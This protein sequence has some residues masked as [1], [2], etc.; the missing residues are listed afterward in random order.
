MSV[1][2]MLFCPDGETTVSARYLV[3]CDG[4]SSTVR[5][6]LGAKLEDY[7]FDEPWLVVDL[8]GNDESDLPAVNTQICDPARPATF[9]RMGPGRHRWE[10]MLLPGETAADMQQ[11][12]T[13]RRLIAERGHRLTAQ[14]ERKAVY[15]F[16][17]LIADFWHKGRVFLAGDAA[18]Q[19]PPFAGQ[20]MC[21]GLRDVFNLAWKFQ[22]VV[23]SGAAADLLE[24]YQPERESNVRFIIESA[25]GLG[26]VVCTTDTAVAA[27]RDAR[28]LADI[29]VGKQPISMSYPPFDKGCVVAGSPGAGTLF[30]QPWAKGPGGSLRF[31][32]LSQGEALLLV[33][34]GDAAAFRAHGLRSM[35]LEEGVA[36]PFAGPLL[37]WLD[38]QSAAAVLIR[39]DFYVFGTGKPQ[40]LAR[41]WAQETSFRAEG[42]AVA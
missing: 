16:H 7:G 22:A 6:L 5:A 13:I 35:S 40:E 17:A 10:F 24:T 28:M 21:S 29:E 38:R 23:K 30:P 3:G 20:G 4:A 32:D 36:A 18:H 12:E 14:I 1:E 39:P 42:S 19:T 25:I 8:I 2:A 41:L 37:E 26:R 9:M 27:E 33:R 11:D 34:Q 31:D 15:R